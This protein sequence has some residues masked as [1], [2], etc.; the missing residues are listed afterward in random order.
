SYGDWSSDV[1]S[2]DL[3]RRGKIPLRNDGWSPPVVPQRDFATAIAAQPGLPEC[4]SISPSH[5]T[6]HRTRGR[7]RA[8]SNAERCPRGKLPKVDGLSILLWGWRSPRNESHVSGP[9]REPQRRRGVGT[10]S[11]GQ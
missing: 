11:S 10:Q 8:A 4:P 3:D 9:D 2:S 1:C 5:R 7:G 6:S